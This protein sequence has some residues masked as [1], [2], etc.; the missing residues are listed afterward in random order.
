MF[1]IV[2]GRRKEQWSGS[3]MARDRREAQ[4]ARGLYGKCSSWGWGVGPGG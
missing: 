1:R 3:G 4:R 2:E